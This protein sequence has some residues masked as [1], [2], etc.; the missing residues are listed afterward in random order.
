[1]LSFDHP[2]VMSLIG[3]CFDGE[4]PLIIMPYM[5]N[6]SVLGYVQKNVCELL[7]DSEGNE[8]EVSIHIIP[9]QTIFVQMHSAVHMSTGKTGWIP[10]KTGCIS[11]TAGCI[12]TIKE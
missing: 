5:S 10:G 8:E 1:M 9:S 11:G 3:V 6:G 4:K 12:Y 7:L 2:N